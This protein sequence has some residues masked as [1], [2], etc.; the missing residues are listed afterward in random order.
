MNP[1]VIFMALL[2][3]DAPPTA[4]I[5][6]L[7]AAVSGTVRD[8]N[9]GKPLAGYTVSTYVGATWIANT[10]QM[11]SG[12]K[13][14]KA[15]TDESGHYK[16]TD[17]PAAP[18][19]ITARDS[20][21]GFGSDVTKHIILNGHDL[22]DLNFDMIVEGTIKGRILD[23]NKEPVPGI[24]VILVSREYYLGQPGYFFRGASAPAN[25]RGEYTVDR[26][27]AG[28]PFYLM[29]ELRRRNLP[30]HSETPLNTM[31][32]R[33]VPMR[34]WY[35][36]SPA[37]EGA[38]PVILRTGETRERVDIEMKKS[39]NFCASGTLLTPTGGPGEL[40]FDIEA[41]QP[42]SGSHEG[43][44]M[45][46]VTGNG[47]TGSDGEFRIC[48]LS[49]GSYRM[50]VSQ[51]KGDFLF[52]T[53]IVNIADED[54]RGLK[55]AALPT[56]SL[57][58]EVVLDGPVP[59]TPLPT[60]VSLSLQPLLR[61]RRQGEGP[62][63]ARVAIPD[64]FTIANTIVDDYAVRATVNGTGLYVKDIQ[65]NGIS[66]NRQALRMTTSAAGTG[67]RVVIG[68]DGGT[69]AAAVTT[70][71]N[72]PAPA[73]RTVAFPAE[74]ASEGTLAAAMVSGQTD[75]TGAWTTQ[76]LA[77]GKYYIGAIDAQIDFTTDFIAR[78]WRS[79][80]R[81]T[82]VDLAPNGTPQVTLEPLQLAP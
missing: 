14:V 30:A 43:G 33:R 78:L 51:N 25:D 50:Q 26:V 18:Y 2:A 36:N 32:R 9:T 37:K 55:I 53:A 48:D 39:A 69:I 4:T 58:G 76:P 44:G 59:V 67:L 79:R 3:Q 64:T 34:T 11:S 74:I 82:E 10:I 75:Q 20:R 62:S 71:D 35:P 8:K 27:P 72:N 60:K 13:E 80:S 73:I 22:E 56:V 19:R 29:A 17:L 45:F 12:T 46:M 77:P 68:Q 7:N 63:G 21:G 65:W 31:L 81:F 15:T 54:L 66:I 5:P 41:Q 57:A 6:I 38:A 49:P 70:K 52:G 24:T 1:L 61:S 23:E 47:R 40:D 28:K 16:L 42:S